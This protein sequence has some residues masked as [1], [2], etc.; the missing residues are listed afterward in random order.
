MAADRPRCAEAAAA[1]GDPA[2]GTA[3]P[4]EQW[5]LVEHPGPWGRDPLWQSGLDPRA[6][7]ALAGWAAAYRGRIVLVRRPGRPGRCTAP[8][9]SLI[10]I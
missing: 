3:P 4:A 1:A 10:H 2:A 9:L 5:F 8:R 7:A 6:A